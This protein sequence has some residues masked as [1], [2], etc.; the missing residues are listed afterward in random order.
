[1]ANPA[2]EGLGTIARQKASRL[3]AE[4]MREQLRHFGHHALT[5]RAMPLVMATGRLNGQICRD[6]TVELMPKVRRISARYLHSYE[7][8][9]RAASSAESTLPVV[10]VALKPIALKWR[11]RPSEV[12]WSQNGANI[13]TA[14]PRRAAN[15]S[16]SALIPKAVVAPGRS[17]TFPAAAEEAMAFDSSTLNRLTDEVIGRIERRFR[18]DRERQG[19]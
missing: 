7:T 4:P 17:P 15:A 11:K 18:I 19:L 1:M 12:D 9:S 13:Q 16:T 5:R 14:T 8:D 2:A 6:R 3:L 10:S